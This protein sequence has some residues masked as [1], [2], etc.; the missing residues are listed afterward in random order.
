MIYMNNVITYHGCYCGKPASNTDESRMLF[1]SCQH[2]EK[3]VMNQ[4]E[5]RWYYASLFS[6][7]ALYTRYQCYYFSQAYFSVCS[8]Q[9]TNYRM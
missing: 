2:S 8:W 6:Y 1:G 3:A 7:L 4:S 9:S 5:V